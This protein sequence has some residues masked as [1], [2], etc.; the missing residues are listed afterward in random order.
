[1]RRSLWF[2]LCLLVG[3]P[4][5]RAQTSADTNERVKEIFERGQVAYENRQ[6]ELAA[7]EFRAAFAL[8]PAAA[9]IYNEAVCYE[10]LGDREHAL[11]LFQKYIGLV[12]GDVKARCHVDPSCGKRDG[13]DTKNVVFIE[14]QPSGAMVYLDSK[15]EAPVGS[16]PWNGTFTGAHKIIVVAPGHQDQTV[17]VTP[18]PNAVQTF[19]VTLARAD[20]KGFLEVRANLPGA[21][22]YIDAKK[23]GAVGRTPFYGDITVGKHVVTVTRDGFTEDERE[24][25][26]EGGKSY[27][28]EAKLA[29]AAVGFVEVHGATV[30]GA[31]VKLDGQTVCLAPCRFSSPSGPHRVTVEKAGRKPYSE[32]LLVGMATQT[33]LGVKLAKRPARTDLIWKFGLAAAA[34]GGGAYLGLRANHIQDS[35]QGDMNKG[36]AVPAD[37]SRYT[38]GKLFAIGA[39]GLF[40]VGG[41]AAAYAVASL[42]WEPGPSST[43]EAHASDLQ[44]GF[45][46]APTVGPGYGGMAAE[47]RF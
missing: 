35:I 21:D 27:K 32:Q 12:P 44:P 17:S 45:A 10:K 38:E 42:I 8:K 37:D 7:S 20:F 3:A 33:S 28:V 19:V 2:L 24:I 16:T 1:M 25:V 47:L 40:V 36:M 30:E 13:D 29:K 6:Y 43:G 15:L 14:S 26:I 5:A 11:A 22:V 39:D 41:L 31:T 9:L 4:V 18:R 23:D 34:V 46:V